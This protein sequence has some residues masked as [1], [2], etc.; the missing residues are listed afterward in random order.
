[1]PEFPSR[2]DIQKTLLNGV[3]RID[4]PYEQFGKVDSLDLFCLNE[5]TLFAFYSINRNRYKRALD[6]GANIGLHSII[7]SRLG[8]SVIAY[9]PDPVHYGIMRRNIDS[10]L[11]SVGSSRSA[12]SDSDAEASFV[13][14]LGNTTGSH[15]EGFKRPHGETEKVTVTTTDAKR[16][17]NWADFAKIDAEGHEVVILSRLDSPCEVMVEVGSRENGEK[18]FEMFHGK[19]HMA[20]QH[21]KWK[22]PKTKEDMPEHHS[23]GSLFIGAVV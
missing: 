9:E 10:N 20:C 21:M 12:V 18:L 13:R 2:A 7:M 5:L 8:W 15:I 19:R 17:F 23:M 1:M 22:S 6:I 4:F 11:V 3:L 16:Q 14:V